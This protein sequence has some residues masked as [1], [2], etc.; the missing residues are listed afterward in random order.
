MAASACARAAVTGFTGASVVGGAWTAVGGG[1]TAWV[2]GGG[3]VTA[4]GSVVDTVLIGGGT[5][6]GG[7]PPGGGVW[8][9]ASSGVVGLTTWTSSGM[10]VE[11]VG[12]GPVCVIST[13]GLC[14]TLQT[15]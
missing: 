10:V 1:A 2:V 3:S 8:L 14:V 11:V 15:P 5:V 7:S 4:V 9:A 12:R 13:G 6:T